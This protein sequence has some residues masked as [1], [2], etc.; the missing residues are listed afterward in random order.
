MPTSRPPSSPGRLL[1]SIVALP[2]VLT[3]GCA[4]SSSGNGNPT[5]PSPQVP[6]MTI[7]SAGVNPKT[8]QV[9]VGGRVR[10][11][12]NDTVTHMMGSDP[13]PDHTDCPEINQVG[14]LLP[15]Q[16][17]ETGNLVQPRT[18]GFHDHERPD[19]QALRGTITIR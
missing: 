4:K 14:F 5:D 12:N 18:C 13:H 15:G 17:R 7:S 1:A 6:T 3:V 16:S 11:V 10:F 8:L 2:L 9:A 19:V